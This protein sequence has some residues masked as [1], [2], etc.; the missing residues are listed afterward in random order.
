MHQ[1]VGLGNCRD[2]CFGI[3]GYSHRRGVGLRV[4]VADEERKRHHFNRQEQHP[5]DRFYRRDDL[6]KC[7]IEKLAS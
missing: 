2:E 4:A 1:P 6:A 5:S 7:R 3:A